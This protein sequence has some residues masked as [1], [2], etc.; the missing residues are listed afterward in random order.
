ME[1]IYSFSLD[2]QISLALIPRGSSWGLSINSAASA[3]LSIVFPSCHIFQIGKFFVFGELLKILPGQT[4]SSPMPFNPS[5]KPL[6]YLCFHSII[7]PPKSSVL[8]RESSN[9]GL[10]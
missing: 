1:V 9:E 6:L 8:H 3:D 10:L 7:S 2:Y 4:I 5:E